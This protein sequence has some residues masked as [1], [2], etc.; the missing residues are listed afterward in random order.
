MIKNLKN[1]Y[2][3]LLITLFAFAIRLIN[4]GKLN[5]WLDEG[6]SVGNVYRGMSF[7][8]NESFINEPNPPLYYFLLNL[9]VKVFGDSEFSVRFPSAVFGALSISLVYLIGKKYVSKRIGTLA[10][11]LII[12]NP[13]YLIYSQ[14]ARVYSFFAFL[15]LCSVYYFPLTDEWKD[16]KKY[17]AVTLLVPWAHAYG[18]FLLLAQNVY[19]VI[20]FISNKYRK[21]LI[22]NWFKIQFLIFSVAAIWYVHFFIYRE[23]YA[24]RIRWI[25]PL[26]FQECYEMLK[27]YIGQEAFV[28]EALV[29]TS[30]VTFIFMLRQKRKIKSM[31]ILLLFLWSFFTIAIPL[32][33]GPFWHPFFIERYTIAASMIFAIIILAPMDLF[34]TESKKIFFSLALLASIF[35]IW[36]ATT[37]FETTNKQNWHQ[38]IKTILE[39]DNFSISIVVQEYFEGSSLEYYI[40][41]MGL[42]KR[43]EVYYLK[44]F[45]QLKTLYK[46]QK[47]FWFIH[48]GNANPQ[49]F[50]DDQYFNEESF[51]HTHDRLQLIKLRVQ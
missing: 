48:A 11:I 36:G 26:T 14:E 10:A 7:I 18:V 21:D 2:E 8:F 23:K 15:C 12:G 17:F 44:D 35:S 40:R 31:G 38:T 42:E 28:F 20:K 5:L 49:G 9:W 6:Y 13:F 37:Y 25:K 34:L 41:K 4:L 32:L 50:L 16:K 27:G 43:I 47:Q 30:L 45:N 24:R 19:I 46:D 33:V 51:S 39:K 1:N 29:I 22:K 3:L